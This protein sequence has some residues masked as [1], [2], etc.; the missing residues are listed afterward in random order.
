VVEDSVLLTPSAFEVE[1]AI[2]EVKIHKS[3]GTHQ[4][5]AE[6]IL[7]GARSYSAFVRYLRRSGNAVGHC[8]SFLYTSRQP[9]IQST[10]RSQWE[11][12]DLLV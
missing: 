3:L 4:I 9:V 5:P 10:G 6:L 11:A 12:T 8:I 2:D 7:A 1:M